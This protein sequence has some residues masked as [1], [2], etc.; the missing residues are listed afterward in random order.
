MLRK[1]VSTYA[2]APPW[3]VEQLAVGI[4]SSELCLGKTTSRNKTKAISSKHDGVPNL[5]KN[6]DFAW[7][8]MTRYFDFNLFC[9]SCIIKININIK[10]W[11]CCRLV[12]YQSG[13]LFPVHTAGG[14]G[15]STLSPIRQFLKQRALRWSQNVDNAWYD[16]DMWNAFQITSNQPSVFQDPRAIVPSS[17]LLWL[18]ILYL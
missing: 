2:N 8:C 10:T 11:V 16:L 6:V 17:F 1:S 13:I 4:L 3:W 14:L 12:F 9:Q 7:L 18:Y 15:K 5:L